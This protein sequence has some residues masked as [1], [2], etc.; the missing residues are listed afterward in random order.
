MRV[1]ILLL[2]VVLCTTIKAQVEKNRVLVVSDEA[3]IK[4]THSIF[5]RSLRER[6]YDIKF[7][8][9]EAAAIPLRKYGDQVYDHVILFAPKLDGPIST[10]EL[11]NYIEAG[12]NVVIAA[13][14]GASATIR[15]MAKSLGADFADPSTSVID[16]IHFDHSD[17]DGHHSVIIADNYV[18]PDIAK[19]TAPILFKGIGHDVRESQLNT[20]I[21]TAA[22]TAYSGRVDGKAGSPKLLGAKNTLISAL[23]ARNG[24]RVVIC[25]SVSFFSDAFFN[26]QVQK[27][28][29]GQTVKSG[30]EE[31][32]REIINWVTGERGQLRYSSVQHYQTSDGVT[33]AQYKVKD[34]M[35]YSIKIEELVEGKW[36]P[37]KADDVQLEF[38]MMDPEIRTNLTHDGSGVFSTDFRIP[39]LMGIYHLKV[40]YRRPGYTPILSST[41]AAVRPFR[42]DEYDR[43]ITSA[44]PYYASAFSMLAGLFVFSVVFLYHQEDSRKIQ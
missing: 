14:T 44:Y 25:G 40:D 6:G 9:A 19:T 43:F 15:D 17:F 8:Q 13:N 10:E 3:S 18:S 24:A 11:Q 7:V 35:H 16:H 22:G 23:Q 41:R 39:D 30:N 4:H 1:S 33:P 29:K 34:N 28:E 5:F 26:A 2:L 20:K 38:I 42:H 27:D 31:L 32:S 37:Y 12:G 36:Q 21:V